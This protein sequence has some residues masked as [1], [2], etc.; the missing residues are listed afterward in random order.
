MTNMWSTCWISTQEHLA[1]AEGTVVEWS[2]FLS[3]L[4]SYDLGGKTCK[5]Q[6]RN[7][8]DLSAMLPTPPP[9]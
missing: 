3:P 7:D 1:E 4:H 6:S 2:L 9:P 5:K 8:Y